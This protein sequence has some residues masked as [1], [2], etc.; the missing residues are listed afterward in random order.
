MPSANREEAV[1]LRKQGLEYAEIGRRLGISREWARQLTLV[2]PKKEKVRPQDKEVLKVADVAKLL[3]LHVNTVRQWTDRGLIKAFRLGNRRDRRYHRAEIVRF[4]KEREPGR[5]NESKEAGYSS[6]PGLP[7]GRT[8]PSRLP[9]GR[10][11]ENKPAQK[12]E[13]NYGI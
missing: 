4:I 8:D 5:Q 9:G 1:R 12:R 3:G 2:L 11:G 7:C 10:A 13:V 6:E